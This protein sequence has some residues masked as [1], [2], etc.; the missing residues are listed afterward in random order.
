MRPV[1][2][3]IILLGSLASCADEGGYPSLK[4][5]P[6]ESA[7]RARDIVPA[8]LPEA[9]ATPQIE[10][11]VVAALAE[12]DAGEARF[13]AELPGVRAAISVA[14]S[15][16]SESWIVAQERL[17]GLDASRAPTVA[18]LTLL[19]TMLIE[20]SG[21]SPGDAT[22]IRAAAAR[23]QALVEAQGA[24]LADLAALLAPA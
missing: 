10:A 24:A 2:P 9:P 6:F 23:V 18:A 21:L 5:R 19:D 1:L 17:S 15:A 11:R 8:P 13:A 16:A 20:G 22:A 14:G 7:G 3:V 4:P 12:A